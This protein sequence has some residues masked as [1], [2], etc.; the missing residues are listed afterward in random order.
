MKNILFIFTLLSLTPFASSANSPEAV[1][2]FLVIQ[3][4]EQALAAVTEGLE[5]Q[6]KNR[7]MLLQKGFLLIK[8][9]KLEE[10]ET[11]YQKVIETIPDDPEPMN[12]LG[13]VYQLQREYGKAIAQLNETIKKFPEFTQAYENLGDTYIQIATAQYIAGRN[14]DPNS[15]SL[16]SK[17]DLGQRFYIAAKENAENALI[18]QNVGADTNVDKV[19]ISERTTVGE[20]NTAEVEKVVESELA[21]FLRS[22]VAGWSSKDTVAYLAHYSDTFTPSQGRSLETW[23]ERKQEIINKAE[24]IKIRV[25]GIK[26]EQLQGSR[27]DLSFNLSYESDTYQSDSRK[28]L[29]L[30]K[31]EGNWLITEEQ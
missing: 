9:R 5:S 4:Y 22:W 30:N 8:M 1:N 26:L 2:E 14:R 21:E 6:P 28:V 13:V 10:A 29:K 25:E 20:E 15:A 7:V 11:H 24:F 18:R 16:I 3:E 23:K 12:N 31:E 17:A 27:A 19:D